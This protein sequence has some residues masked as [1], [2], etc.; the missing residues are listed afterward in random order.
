[1]ASIEVT[2]SPQGDVVAY[3]ISDGGTDW[4]IWRF[5]RVADGTTTR[6]RWRTPSTTLPR[7]LG[8]G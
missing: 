3:A 7:P 8:C 4:Q 6:T 5:R 1:M 2:P